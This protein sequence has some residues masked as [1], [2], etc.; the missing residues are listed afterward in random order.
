MSDKKIDRQF[1]HVCVGIT[2]CT[3]LLATAGGRALASPP[4]TGSIRPQVAGVS[5]VGWGGLEPSDGVASEGFGQ[6]VA[7]DGPLALVGTYFAGKAYVFSYQGGSWTQQTELVVQGD[8]NLGNA[9]A[10]HDGTAVVSSNGAA[11][12]FAQSGSTW[13]EQAKLPG[14][15]NGNAWFGESVSTDGAS[16]IVGA[17]GDS[18]L[19][20]AAYVFVR[21]GSSW[22]QQGAALTTPDSVPWN[23]GGYEGFGASVAMSGGLAVVG[24]PGR[25][26]G[27][28]AA[29]VF[30]F[31]GTNWVQQ[32]PALTSPSVTSFGSSVALSGGLAL[33]GAPFANSNAGSGYVYAATG[34]AWTLQQVLTP[35]EAR[36]NDY[37]GSTVGLVGS[38]AVL[39]WSLGAYVFV[40]SGGAWSEQASFP[41]ATA[42]VT[43]LAMN[44]SEVIAGDWYNAYNGKNDEGAAYVYQLEGVLGSSCTGPLDCASTYSCTGTGAHADAGTCSPACESCTADGS[45]SPLPDGTSCNAPGKACMVGTCRA[46]AC[47]GVAAP[48]C[49]PSDPCHLAGT[50]DPLTGGC[51]SPLVSDG[52]PCPGGVCQGGACVESDAG[53]ADGGPGDAGPLDARSIGDA[54]GESG[55]TDAE[56]PSEASADAAASG[57]QAGG[58][59]GCSCRAA[60][61]RGGAC[62]WVA[63]ALT[64]MVLGRR[65]RAH[66]LVA[67]VLT[68]AAAACGGGGRAPAGTGDAD[69]GEDGKVV[70]GSGGDAAGTTDG[71][72]TDAR[73][74]ADSGSDGAM[75]ATVTGRV[76]AFPT[77]GLFPGVNASA[78]SGRRVTLL[79]AAGRK[80]EAVTDASGA[81][82]GSGVT[83]PYDAL[84]DAPSGG[85]ASDSGPVAFLS[86]DTLHPR[87]VA[88]PGPADGALGPD[89]SEPLS[90][91]Q[92]MLNVPLQLPACASTWCNY[93]VVV[94]DHVSGAALGGVTSS[95]VSQPTTFT[96]VATVAWYGGLTDTVDVYVLAFDQSATSY[97]Y[98]A[99]TLGV[100]VQDKVT[101]QVPQTIAP[102]AVNNTGAF[103]LSASTA[104]VP[105]AWG[106][107][108]L[109]VFLG[110]PGTQASATLV[111]VNSTSVAIQVPDLLG[112]TLGVQASSDDP[113]QSDPRAWVEAAASAL[114]LT[115]GNEALTLPRPLTV[116]SPA[117]GATI[118][119]STG[120]L[121]WMGASKTQV[122]LAELLAVSDAGANAFGAYVFTS[123]ASID[124]G[125]LS[126]MGL[127]LA[128]GPW[129]VVLDGIGKVASLDAILD[130]STLAV[131]DNSESSAIEW[132]VVITP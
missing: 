99:R 68:A 32:G 11:Y 18:L 59:S 130:E 70:L 89:A 80:T 8:T 72:A 112:A 6:S 102:T 127:T 132:R 29:Y 17:P 82:H 115:T 55:T 41:A 88:Q 110:I 62:P 61:G 97:W 122:I 119:A 9:V 49:A 76:V 71:N 54:A 35:A 64:M 104:S 2:A 98:G 22:V 106:A 58:R 53:A 23:G 120:T 81:F 96:P 26:N 114:P 38:T 129:M 125:R 107:P 19:A 45:C 69:A 56:V 46:G 126:T 117:Y 95:Y 65:R 128:P 100:L 101:T 37:V 121:S 47:S 63:A 84:V 15:S 67:G 86:I 31:N 87:L 83:P 90:W 66:V 91:R 3:L 24:Y 108:R 36:T 116:A 94:A 40:Q 44:G 7:I 1:L 14:P 109:Y 57:A 43:S 105:A 78:I 111:Q 73:A 93:D 74:S 79:D 30:G 48:T 10:L 85:S 12:V 75:L 21:S 39:G 123:G 28:G 5:Q 113:S 42:H 4:A 16:I 51:S 103:T 50:C 131:P 77:I 33:V 92:A 13:A 34:G 52:T 124:L 25:S 20:G 118:S 60:S 27:A